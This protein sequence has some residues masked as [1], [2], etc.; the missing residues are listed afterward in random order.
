MRQAPAPPYVKTV[1]PAN[2]LQMVQTA[3][4]CDRRVTSEK[5]QHQRETIET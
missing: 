2:I 3:I 5:R 4:G 1:V